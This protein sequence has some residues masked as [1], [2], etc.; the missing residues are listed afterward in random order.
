MFS[1]EIHPQSAYFWRVARLGLKVPV[2]V[3]SSSCRLGF[4]SPGLERKQK[5]H[6]NSCNCVTS[7]YFSTAWP[8]EK[9]LVLSGFFHAVAML[10]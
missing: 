9:F 7:W 10:I 4:G 8:L 3:V 2:C 5:P 1:C 6:L